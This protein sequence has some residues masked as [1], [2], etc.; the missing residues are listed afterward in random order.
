MFRNC[1][2]NN[3][4]RQNMG[5]GFGAPYMMQGGMNT[6]PIMECQVVEP[7]ITKCVEQEFYHEVPQV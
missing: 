1:C 6:Q 7:T 3:N 5:M 2:C 4:A